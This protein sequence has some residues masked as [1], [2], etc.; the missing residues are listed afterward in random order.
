MLESPSLPSI[1]FAGKRS[2]PC[3]TVNSSRFCSH[4][5]NEECIEAM[6]AFASISHG[7]ASVNC[8]GAIDGYLLHTEA[9]PKSVIG[10]GSYF[11]GHYQQYGV[12]IQA[13]C[14]HL[15]RFTYIAVAGPGVMNDNQAINEVDIAKLISNLPFSFCVI[16]DAATEKLVPMYYGPDKKNAKFHNFFALQLR[17]WIE[18]AFGMMQKKWG[19]LWRPLV[20]PLEKIKYI[21]EVIA[22]LHNYC[23]D[24]RLLETGGTVDLVVEANITGHGTFEEAL[25]QLAQYKAILENLPS[26]SGNREQMVQ[27]IVNLG[28]EHSHLQ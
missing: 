16:G 28:L 6:S 2:S 19:I 24:E 3:A 4:K 7:E 17:I 22:R 20:V 21:V 23:I 12:N 15:S 26:F 11:S 18:M 8:A 9:P 10:N 1:A 25:E 13:C 5:T 27:R 14:D